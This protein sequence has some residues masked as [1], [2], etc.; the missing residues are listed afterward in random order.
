MWDSLL[1]SSYLSILFRAVAV[2][3]FIVV[4]IRLFGKKE[5][6]QLSVTDLLFILLISNAVQ[7][8]MVGP[9]TSLAGGILAATALFAVNYLLKQILY[10][11]QKIS[12]FVQGQAVLLIYKGVV[13]E[14]HLKKVE[15]TLE[16]LKAAVREHG[17][18]DFA[19]VDLA[20][21]EV[22]GN[23]SIISHNVE[24]Q[25][26]VPSNARKRRLKARLRKS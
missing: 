3:L 25:T 6:T 23:I 10:R 7:N 15:I 13:Q 17:V 2:Y 18:E 20:V 12:N 1:H 4:A 5:L 26:T 21:L 16:E 11:N 19:S 8:A 24:K 22:D 14:D 9:D